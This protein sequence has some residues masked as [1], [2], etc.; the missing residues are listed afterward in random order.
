MEKNSSICPYCGAEMEKG[1]LSGDGRSPIQYSIE[2]ESLPIIDSIKEN[3][4]HFIVAKPKFFGYAV[5]E[6]FRCIKCR[7]IIIDYSENK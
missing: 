3:E 5:K 1:K 6:C 2:K 4:R 7:K